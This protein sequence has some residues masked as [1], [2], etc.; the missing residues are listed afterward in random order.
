M[1]WDHV[2]R[3]KVLQAIQAYDRLGPEA[4]FMVHGFAARAVPPLRAAKIVVT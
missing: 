2:T 3:T 1:A 4:V